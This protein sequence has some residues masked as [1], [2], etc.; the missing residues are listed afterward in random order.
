MPNIAKL[1]FLRCI[2]QADKQRLFIVQSNYVG[3]ILHL[4]KIKKNK[5]EKKIRINN[6]YQVLKNLIPKKVE[7]DIM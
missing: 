1:G 4:A 6:F 2:K 5:K 3:S 7:I